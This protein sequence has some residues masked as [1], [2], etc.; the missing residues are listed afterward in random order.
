[1]G[2]EL[3][4]AAAADAA[5][6]ADL[7][8]LW[9]T[10]PAR[11]PFNAPTFLRRLAEASPGPGGS[12]FFAVL[13]NADHHVAA[14]WPLRLHQRRQL[15]FL[16]QNESDYCAPIVGPAVPVD[17]LAAGLTEAMGRTRARSMYLANVRAGSPEGDAIASALGRARWAHERVGAWVSPVFRLSDPAAG[18]R[19]E[20]IDN[21]K[22]LRYAERQL[23]AKGTLTFEVLRGDDDLEN[24]VRAFC[25]DHEWRWNPTRTPS[26]Y[27]H[28]AN[29]ERLLAMLTAWAADDVL[30]RFSERLDERR[31]SYAIALASPRSLVYHAV[32]YCPAFAKFSPS[33]LLLRRIL[34]WTRDTGFELLDLGVGDEAYKT[35]FSNGTQQ[36]E[37]FYASRA[38]VSPSVLCGKADRA[39]RASPAL[40][41]VHDRVI[42][43]GAREIVPAVLRGIRGRA[44]SF[45][46][47][48][49]A[50]GMSTTV[51]RLLDRV[52]GDDL[53]FVT[54]G[55]GASGGPRE[56]PLDAVMSML[57]DETGLGPAERAHLFA[58]QHAGERVFGV[59]E[60]GEAVQ[61]SWLRP[62]VAGERVPGIEPEAMVWCIYD[63]R[64]ARRAAGRGLYSQVLSAI[65]AS[66]P[67]EDF[68]VIYTQDWNRAS[69]RGIARAGFSP[70]ARRRRGAT[71]VNGGWVS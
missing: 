32:S 59:V 62:A 52:R 66:L 51:R 41:A 60:N 34:L 5:F 8:E 68:I 40:T 21:S 7:R 3:V 55:G 46:R 30:I 27:R 70:A 10:D 33:M 16:N 61:V 57:E 23:R 19:L 63:C 4:D 69:Q 38:R 64:T 47:A 12:A 18:R 53:F 9:T 25:D 6:Y 14:A 1:M 39:L 42:N 37:R 31:F 26:Q 48:H 36:L 28:P 17:A 35:R 24:W 2:W 71:G 56:L 65:V 49:L 44:T 15:R 50:A 67:A 20:Q 58:R 11:L 54:A 43:R 22:N 13:R 45:R 29:R